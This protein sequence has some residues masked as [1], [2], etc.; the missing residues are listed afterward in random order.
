L[1]ASARRPWR[2][3]QFKGSGSPGLGG[4]DSSRSLLLILFMS[5][6]IESRGTCDDGEG[7][8]VG[9]PKRVVDRFTVDFARPYLRAL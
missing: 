3:S 8:P 5:S 2:A 9:G 1:Q 6:F 7:S 4:R